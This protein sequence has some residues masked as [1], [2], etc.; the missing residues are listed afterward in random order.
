MEQ[1][2]EAINEFVNGAIGLSLK[3]MIIQI[4]G[5]LLLFL[6]VRHYFWNNITDYLDERKNHMAKEYEEADEANKEA[7][8]IKEKVSTELVEI[9]MNAKGII[10]EAKE[11]GELERIGIV[12]NAKTE[13]SVVIEN[14]RKEIDSEIEKART[15]I[16]DEIVSVA[17]L[18]AEKVIKKEIDES[19]HK[20]LLKEVTEEVIS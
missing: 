6:V 16:N 11:R 12:K 15:K 14:A 4:A 10:D 2:A 3:E 9:R 17:V 13:A 18:M 8:S 1:V 7:Q 19:K 5:T 20:E